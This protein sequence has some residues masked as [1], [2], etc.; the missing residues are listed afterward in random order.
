MGDD[1][2][3]TKC[4]VDALEGHCKPRSNKIVAATAYEQLVQGDLDLLEQIEKCREVTAVCNFEATYDKCLKNAFL[5]GLRNQKVCEK[6]IEVGDKL[7]STDQ[8]CIATE[9]YNSDWQLSI[10]QSLIA[11]TKEATAVQNPSV[12]ELHV[13]KTSQSKK[14][15]APEDRHSGHPGQSN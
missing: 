9:V 8:I 1:A 14:E 15:P 7:A 3:S 4:I 10:K 6:C 11:T 12:S 5:L 13:V 2:T